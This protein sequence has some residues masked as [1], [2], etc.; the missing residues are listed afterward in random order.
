M[1]RHD[2]GI[3]IF[4]DVELLDFTGPY[5]VFSRTRMT[6]GVESRRSEDSAPFR[7]QTIAPQRHEVVTTGGLHVQADCIFS[8]QPKPDL[9]LVPGG[10]GTRPLLEDRAVLDWIRTTANDAT[11]VTS[12]CS[13][14]MLLAAAGLLQ[15]KRATSHYCVYDRLNEIDPSIEVV[16]NVRYVEDGIVTSAGV[17]AGIDMAFAMVANI[18]GHDVAVETAAYIEYPWKAD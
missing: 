11:W 2:V 16:R 6:P 7:V 1:K 10:F 14:S 15:G 5:E 9:L 18:C 17:A 4:D 3:L 13:G 8:D 12:V